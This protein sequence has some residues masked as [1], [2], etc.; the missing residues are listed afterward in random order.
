MFL[1]Y[2]GKLDQIKMSEKPTHIVLA[3]TSFFVLS[4]VLTYLYPFLQ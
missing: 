4:L 3:Y 2:V 1:C